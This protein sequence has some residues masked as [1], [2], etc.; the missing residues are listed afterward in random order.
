[1]QA[2]I[3]FLERSFKHSLRWRSCRS[4]GGLRMV[5]WVN[6][7]VRNAL[8]VREALKVQR[9]AWRL[10]LCHEQGGKRKLKEQRKKRKELDAPQN[11]GQQAQPSGAAGALSK[12]TQQRPVGKSVQSGPGASAEA[13]RQ[14]ASYCRSTPTVFLPPASM[15]N[16]RIPA[17]VW[18]FVCLY[19]PW[20]DLIYALRLVNR[21]WLRV[22]M[23]CHSWQSLA[24]S[25]G[26]IRDRHLQLFGELWRNIDN[27]ILTNPNIPS[28]ESKAAF[29]A[30]C[31]RLTSIFVNIDQLP[32]LQTVCNSKQLRHVRLESDLK[33]KKKSKPGDP[34]PAA[35]F[36]SSCLCLRSAI[37]LSCSSTDA[38]LL[39]L[40]KRCAATLNL[41]LVD[42][43]VIENVL[44]H[45]DEFTDVGFADAVHRFRALQYVFFYDCQA[46]TDDA[47]LGLVRGC[48]LTL[49][50]LSV[51]IR[52][53]NLSR[54]LVL[55]TSAAFSYVGQHCPRLTSLFLDCVLLPG[56]Q[57][58]D[59][60]LERSRWRTLCHGCPRLCLLACALPDAQADADDCVA[61]LA[62]HCANLHYFAPMTEYSWRM[63]FR[64][65][66]ISDMGLR[67]LGSCAFL[68]MCHLLR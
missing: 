9:R 44:I 35:H 33:F 61:M 37:L 63:C 3:D 18:R 21:F 64:P 20:H 30:H 55:L 47:L 49:S 15:D 7:A 40:S 32:L 11:Q 24:D 59:R 25:Q 26:T 50:V 23:D 2:I 39:A 16:C 54:N 17:D 42:H 41:L 29:L 65:I 67:A 5:S 38:A 68:C 22:V 1:M 13:G 45:R 56:K 51:A 46:V 19:L 36:L 62:D 27:F 31:T 6:D 60:E 48:G 14:L 53:S 10:M 66:S 57:D 58:R 4:R 34:D 28:P 12:C 8:R 52:K 43:S